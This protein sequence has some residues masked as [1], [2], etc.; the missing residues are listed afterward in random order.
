MVALALPRPL[1]RQTLHNV[2][3]TPMFHHVLRGGLLFLFF[4]L[5]VLVHAQ[6]ERVSDNAVN[7]VA[8]KMYCPVCENIP[9]DECQTQACVDW[10]EEIRQQLSEGQ[11][12]QAVIESFVSRFGDQVVGIPQDP[13][14]RGLTLL[15]PLFAAL[16]AI[17]VGVFTFRRFGAHQRLSLND[18]IKEPA[19]LSDEDYRLRLEKDLAARR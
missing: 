2:I 18:E 1:A 14:L 11:T 19:A 8:E 12:E 5:A 15:M 16:L 3:E 17:A 7:A 10:K 13:V 4:A 6:G 9:L